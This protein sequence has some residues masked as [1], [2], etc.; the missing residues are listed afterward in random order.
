MRYG[1]FDDEARE[2]VITTPHT[3]YPWINYLGSEQFFS[4]LSHQAGGYSFYRDAKMRRLTRYRYNNIP[5]DAGG[6]YLYV[7]DGGDVWTPSW[8]PVKADLDH[9]EAR[10]GLGYSRITGERN[11]VRVETSFFVPVGETAEVQKVTITNTSDADKTLSLFSFVE[12]C[13]W[14]AQDD[15]TNYQRNLSIGEVEVEQESPHGSAIYHRTEY[16]ERRDHYAVFAVNTRADGFD[17]DRDSFVGAYNSLGEAT[18]PLKGEATNSVASGWYPIGS[19]QVNVSLAPGESRDLVY[20]L[21]YVENP[22]EEKWADDAHQIVNKERAHA[23]LSRFATAEQADAALAE[24]QDYWTQLLSTYSVT[25]SDDKLDRMVNIWNQYQCMVTFNMSRSASFFE[26]G[27]GRGM[28]FRDSNQD[29]LGFVHLIPERARERIIDIASTQFADG[30][31]YHQYQPLTKRGNNDIGSGFNDDPLWLIAG[32]A[33][34]IKETGDFSILD[35]PVPFDNEPGS[36]VPLFE[37]LTRSFEFT[38]T[39]RGPHGLPLI[40]RADWNDCLNLNCFSTTPGESFQTT[41]NQAGGV[42]ESTFIA[43]QFVLYGEQYAELAARRGL[44]DVADRARGYVAEMRD[45][46]LTDGWDGAWFLRAYDYYGNPIGTDAHDEGKIWIEPQ[47]FAVMAGVG[48]GEGPQDTDAPAIKAL[49]S[50]NELLA[51]DH[52]MVLQYPAYTTYQVHMGEV[53][54]YPPGYKEN[55]G[56][57]CHNNPWVIIAETVVGRGAR[58]FDYYKRITPAYREDISDVHRL[59]PYVYAQM[60]AGKEAVRHGEAK[61]SWLT[62]TAAWNF[63]TVSQYL[64]GVRPEY[65]GLVVDPQIGP[66]VPSFT[67]TRVARGATYE[68]VVT[69]SGAEGARGRLVVDGTPVEGN[70]VP[71]A[72]A[73]ATVRVEVTV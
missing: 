7:N 46:L 67:V 61:N 50:V 65:D 71:Y 35:E 44:A 63:V 41:E 22:D 64:L 2:Y 45:A 37:H 55:G 57:F 49:D 20:V 15:Q 1:H 23:L 28:G 9:F 72:P 11:G 14:N 18:V 17:T 52:G 73:G 36:E 4:L 47:G 30:S 8:L 38:V 69:N 51:T 6:R 58:A 59:E 42:A 68:I 56:I 12:F 33:A 43:A 70:V 31:A 48:V 16:R 25:S 26:T 32:T 3:P 66:E 5:A 60:I 21:G 62:G 27:I 19:H 29:L 40:G 53:S 54:T 24:L 13:L 10:H 34:Y 39:H